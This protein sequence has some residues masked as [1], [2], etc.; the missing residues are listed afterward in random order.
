MAFQNKNMSVLAYANAFTLWH[1]RSE[2][3]IE[4]IKDPKYFTPLY[5][6]VNVGD[7]IILNCANVDGM[8]RVV[9]V[10]KDAV[11]IAELN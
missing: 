7:I 3:T 11:E 8:R 5:T 6:L 9:S 10:D 4:M 1:Y 2:D